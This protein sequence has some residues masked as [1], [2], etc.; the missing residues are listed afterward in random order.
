[1][2]AAPRIL[3]GTWEEIARHSGELVGHHLKVIVDPQDL[4][5]GSQRT[6]EEWVAWLEEWALNRRPVRFADD[7][8]D[9]IYE[10]F[11]R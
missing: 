5:G 11:L 2:S 8:R 6:P 10:E 1:M 9:A 3:E 7:S 4:P